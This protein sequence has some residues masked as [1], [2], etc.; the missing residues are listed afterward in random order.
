MTLVPGTRLGP[1]EVD[2][3]IGAGGM[4]EVYRARD[5]KL[6][7]AVALKVLPESVASDPER[8]ARFDREARTLA[9]LSHP[10][11][12][13]IHGVEDAGGTSALVLELVEGPTLADRIAAGPVPVDESIAIARQIADA[14]QA[15]HEQ[16]IIHRDLKPANI[17]LGD[18][19]TVKVLDFGLAKLVDPVSAGGADA[20]ASPTITS[21]A[22]TAAGVILGTAAYMSPEQA[23]G[24]AA[25]KRSDI[26]AFGCVLYEM[27]TGERAFAG[28]DVGESIASVLRSEP[29]WSQ[30][31]RDLPPVLRTLLERCLVKDRRKRISDIAAAQFVLEDFSTPGRPR[32][33]SGES[34]LR[35]H[36]LLPAAAAV[37]VTALVAAVA[38]WIWWPP[39]TAAD[40]V[41]F[42]FTLTEGQ[43]TGTGRRFID[44]SPDGKSIAYVA[45][46]QLYLRPIDSLQSQAIQGSRTALQGLVNPMFSPDSQSIAFLDIASGAIKRLPVTGGG[47]TTI[48]DLK[49]VP[50]AATWDRPGILFTYGR[51]SIAQDPELQGIFQVSPEGGVA[52]RIAELR[53]DEVAM[54]PQVLP[55]GRTLVFTVSTGSGD[56][57]RDQTQVVAQSLADGTRTVLVER[58]A[59]ARYL[60]T[61]HLLYA[62]SGIVF[63]VPFDAAAVRVTGPPVPVIEGVA[64]SSISGSAQYAISANGSLVYVPGPKENVVLR[65]LAEHRGGK[66][67]ILKVAPD[68]Y[69]HPRVSRDNI[70]IVE[71]QSGNESDVWAY[72]LSGDAEIR[73]VTF[74]GNNRYPIWSADGE[75]ITFQSGR[76]KDRGIWWQPV[77]GGAATRLTRA[78]DDEAHIP[79]SW[80]HDGRFLLFSNGKRGQFTLMVLARDSMKITPF[81]SPESAEYFSATFSPDDRWVAYAFT[82]RAGGGQTPDRGVYVERFPATSEKHQAPKVVLDFHPVWAPDGKRIFFISSATAPLVEMT[83]VT[84]PAVKFQTP[85]AQPTVPRPQ[86][87]SG[88]PRGYDVGIDGRIVSVVQSAFSDGRSAGE[89]RVVLNW[90]EELRRRVPA[91]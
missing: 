46:S 5:T 70:L 31:P 27:L 7:R 40:A 87:R 67:T 41:Q 81:G 72:D 43:F 20:T 66:T 55:D 65:G 4:G 25:D 62:V 23:K 79:E 35:T 48:T 16:G 28:E 84:T 74:G 77:T 8:R 3:L 52:R 12:A 82:P 83:V 47:A 15:A 63:A 60:P 36:W 88:D 44:I 38:A 18:D 22:M 6:G 21:P 11:I 53:R 58:G 75:R 9:T 45:D 14:L 59:Y 76:E 91:K 42:S 30:L 10:N 33:H 54:T 26:W 85:V 19:G 49:V 73:R 1:Y 51:A 32:D 50:V 80:S 89:I 37:V 68:Y 90:S 61:G 34:R 17:K 39:V 71:R 2:A 29:D 24:R 64:R 13:I 56:E 78:G 57:L 69:S 86:L